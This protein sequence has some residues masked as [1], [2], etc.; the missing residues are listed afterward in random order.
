MG[1]SM[2][3]KAYWQ[4]I[5]FVDND[6]YGEELALNESSENWGLSD[7]EKETLWEMYIRREKEES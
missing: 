3:D 2:L 5:G 7:N 1:K 6:G 4:M